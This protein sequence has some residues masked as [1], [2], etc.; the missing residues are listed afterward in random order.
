MARK[1]SDGDRHDFWATLVVS[2]VAVLILYY[3]GDPV[4]GIAFF[5][6]GLLQTYWLS[7][8]LDIP[9]NKIPCKAWH[10]WKRLGLGWYWR[11]YTAL[12]PYHRHIASHLPG[13]GTCLRLLYLLWFPSLLYS[14]SAILWLY[15]V[16]PAPTIVGLAIP[17]YGLGLAV[18]YLL[19]AIAADTVHWILDGCPV[20][21]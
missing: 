18:C 1:W 21:F 19:G 2:L 7:P 11:L 14:A 9:S 17:F 20:W 6:G 12:I 13:L 4:Y 5:V 16:L 15:G 10:R 3:K 8:D